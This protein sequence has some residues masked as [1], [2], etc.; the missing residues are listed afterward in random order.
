MHFICQLAHTPTT[1]TTVNRIKNSHRVLYLSIYLPRASTHI[2]TMCGDDHEK[3]VYTLIFY[4][5]AKFS[6]LL[7]DDDDDDV[8]VFRNFEFVC[9][10]RSICLCVSAQCTLCNYL[11]FICFPCPFAHGKRLSLRRTALM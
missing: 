10:P 11:L 5:D 4:S 2:H 3:W 8:H 9:A 1:T 7:C 6:N